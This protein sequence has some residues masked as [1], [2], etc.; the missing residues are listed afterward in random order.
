MNAVWTLGA[1]ADVQC[2]Y[3]RLESLEEGAGDQ[4]YDEVLSSVSVLEAFPL[5]GP[6][7]YRAKVRRACVQSLLRPV[8]CGGESWDYSA[9]SVGFAS[10]PA[11]GHASSQAYV[12][13]GM[14][15]CEAPWTAC[16]LLPVKKPFPL[17][18]TDC[19]PSS[20]ARSRLRIQK[21]QQGCTQ[22]KVLRTPRRKATSARPCL[23][24]PCFRYF[25]LIIN[26]KM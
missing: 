13:H 6:V 21:R 4:F 7:V 18:T 3:E 10:R 20:T 16:S 1:E 25:G 14:E 2:V 26:A 23:A 9:R 24:P 8:L 12:R 17:Q 15:A 19:K 5:I 22:S 11:S